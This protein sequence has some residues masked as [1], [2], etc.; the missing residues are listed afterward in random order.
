MN[1]SVTLQDTRI[2]YGPAD[3]AYQDPTNVEQQDGAKAGTLNA[4]WTAKLSGMYAFPMGVNL[5]GFLNMRQGYPFNRT[6]QSP[7]R[8]GALGQVDVM[9]DSFGETRLE[10]FYQV[11]ARAE[12]VFRFQ[13]RTVSFAVD[14]FNVLNANTVLTRRTRQ[15]AS[16]ANDAQEILAPRVA[17]VGLKV[18]F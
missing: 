14:V 15:N 13:G 11:D 10:N 4:D 1:A 8:T 17:R 18:N 5:S 3:L 2:H 9:I 12:K 16:N 7:S 6:V